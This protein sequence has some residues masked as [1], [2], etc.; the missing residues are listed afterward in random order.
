MLVAGLAGV[1][2]FFTLIPADYFVRKP[3]IAHSGRSL[4]KRIRQVAMNIA[5]IFLVVFGLIMS[6][7][8]VPGPGLL[9][10]LIGISFT[11]FPGKRSLEIWIIRK[12]L[13]LKPCNWLRRKWNRGPILLP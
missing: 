9:I 6:L 2:V 3:E 10:A 5:G 11:D 8:L 1:C 4:A 13:V 12:P 7:P